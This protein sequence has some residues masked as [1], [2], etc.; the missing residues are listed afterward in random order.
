MSEPPTQYPVLAKAMFSV[1]R[2][3][4][5]R[6]KCSAQVRTQYEA[7]QAP[8]VHH[9]IFAS[10]ANHHRDLHTLM[11]EQKPAPL[12]TSS[13]RKRPRTLRHTSRWLDLLERVFGHDPTCPRC[14][15]TLQ[16]IQV[17]HSPLVID[18]ILNHLGLPTDLPP[19]APARAPPGDGLDLCF[20]QTLPS[21]EPCW[22]D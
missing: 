11:P 15:G 19:L 13:T 17:V 22:L 3:I 18:A 5:F 10:N 8:P 1:C 12:V 16:L 9:G 2:S 21:T 7:S 14:R 20:A 4:P 6:P